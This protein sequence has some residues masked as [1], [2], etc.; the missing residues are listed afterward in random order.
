MRTWWCAMSDGSRCHYCR[1]VPCECVE[2]P[3]PR[4]AEL[5]RLRARMAELDD[6]KRAAEVEANLARFERDNLFADVQQLQIESGKA[7]AEQ[8]AMAE[9]I[10]ALRKDRDAL[11]AQLEADRTKVAE[12]LTAA[13]KT[14]DSWYWLTEGRGC[15]EWDDDRY[16]EEFKTAGLSIK[17]SLA[18]L[19][20]IAAD[21]T[22]C[23]MKSDE[24]AQARIDW[25]KRALEAEQ[26][27]ARLE[28]ALGRCRQGYQNILEFRRLPHPHL[29]RYGA[30]TREELEQSIA[31]IDAALEG[32]N[33]A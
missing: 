7:R 19:T 6:Q 33:G 12:C 20:K 9:T 10:L 13:N 25:E 30:L 23:P 17:A 29:G 11:S 32:R 14:L 22:G 27:H 31:E 1:R 15:Y 2:L 21:W 28:K 24:V 18:P 3:D 4:N 26:S 5:T 16:R 8:S